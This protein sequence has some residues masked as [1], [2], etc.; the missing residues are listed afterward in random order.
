MQ[1]APELC[2]YS[3]SKAAVIGLAKS[4]SKEY[5]ETGITVNSLGPGLIR[6]EMGLSLGPE[7]VDFYSKTLPMKRFS[8]TTYIASCIRDW[9]PPQ[10]NKRVKVKVKGKYIQL[11]LASYYR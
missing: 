8:L 1:G 6:T 4:T 3:C 7:A 9:A 11:Q 5:A 10:N 2:A